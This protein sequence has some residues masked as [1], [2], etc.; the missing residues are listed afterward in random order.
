MLY[1]TLGPKTYEN[2]S[3]RVPTSIFYCYRKFKLA[4]RKV[5][6]I[7]IIT[8]TS[9]LTLQF[10]LLITP[11]SCISSLGLSMSL[12]P[13]TNQG[14][15]IW[16]WR[17]SW[18][19]SVFVYCYV[20]QCLWELILLISV[21]SSVMW[22]I[23]ITMKNWSASENSW[24][25]L[26]YIASTILFQLVLVILQRTHLPLMRPMKERQFILSVHFI[27]PVLILLPQRLA[28]FTT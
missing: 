22:L 8:L 28:L 16:W 10:T 12:N 3:N 9:F 17:S 2:I 26:L 23:D 19:L 27:F 14:I 11:L 18:L 21:H 7:Y 6:P 4:H 25:N 5:L 20:R 15:L 1:M 13:T 24:N